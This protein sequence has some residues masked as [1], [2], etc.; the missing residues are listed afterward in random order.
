MARALHD[1]VTH[2]VSAIGVH[3]GAAR[4]R[5]TR[6]GGCLGHPRL[7]QP[8][9]GLRPSSRSAANARPV[10]RTAVERGQGARSGERRGTRERRAGDGDHSTSGRRRSI[11]RSAR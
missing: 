5:L 2:H 10:A 1:V 11:A 4:P 7:R 3:A 6:T 8:G 9:R